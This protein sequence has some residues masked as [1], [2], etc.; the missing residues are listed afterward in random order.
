LILTDLIVVEFSH[1]A[2][3]N[4]LLVGL[5]GACWALCPSEPV[6][7]SKVDNPQ[8]TR[9]LTTDIDGLP[10]TIVQCIEVIRSSRLR[11]NGLFR[12]P[13]LESHITSLKDKLYAGEKIDNLAEIDT[14]SIASFI[15]AYFRE[16]EE[17]LL[18]PD[19]YQNLVMT[20]KAG[21]FNGLGKH[22]RTLPTQSYQAFLYLFQFF[23]D[24]VAE[25]DTNF[26]T[27]RNLAVVFG[28][29]LYRSTETTP[30]S[31]VSEAVSMQQVIEC[32]I[33]QIASAR[34]GQRTGWHEINPRS[35]RPS[36][37]NPLA[38]LLNSPLRTKPPE[39]PE[40]SMKRKRSGSTLFLG[41]PVSLDEVF[42]V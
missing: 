6:T 9:A 24:V 25:A 3:S 10:T 32:L 29:N 15:K 33:E 11:E 42:E 40:E 8:L 14:H 38:Q 34:C 27:P 7:A 28:P 30:E 1:F 39:P 19:I 37:I 23:S 41:P 18:S 21:D 36:L 5:M 35:R 22:V 16:R 4:T 31:V 13:G 26:M 20:Y 12:V 2:T 17:P